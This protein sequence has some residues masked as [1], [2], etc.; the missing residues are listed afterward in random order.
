MKHEIITIQDMQIIGMSREI[1]FKAGPEECPKFWQEEYVEKIVRPVFM[2]GKTPND[3][4]Q[5]AI[6]NNVGEFGLCTCSLPNHD[7]MTCADVNYN[8]WHLRDCQPRGR[9]RGES[10]GA[11]HLANTRKTYRKQ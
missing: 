2:E 9:H 8:Q 5:A 7:C 6:D 4:Q 3:F 10:E 11:K 1:A